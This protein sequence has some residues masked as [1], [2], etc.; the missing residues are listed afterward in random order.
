MISFAPDINVPTWKQSL[1]QIRKWQPDRLFL[2]HFGPSE[3]VTRHLNAMEDNLM[4]WA[5][6]VRT[7]LSEQGTDAERAA[8]FQEWA[9]A[10]IRDGVP[11]ALWPA[12]EAFGQPEG[13]WY[14]LARY[15]RKARSNT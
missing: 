5:E 3:G 7:S 10:H 12:F 11:Q 9:M 14:G 2:T 1:D 8:I 15:R 4:L 13:S 6:T